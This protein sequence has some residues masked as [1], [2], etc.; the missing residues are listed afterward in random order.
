MRA[1]L[2]PARW[3]LIEIQSSADLDDPA[4]VETD[5][6]VV[7]VGVELD[8]QLDVKLQQA[9]L[10]LFQLL[11]HL[12]QRGLVVVPR[13]QGDLFH[14]AS[15]QHRLAEPNKVLDLVLQPDVRIFDDHG[16]RALQVRPHDGFVAV[17]GV[18]V[19]DGEV[20]LFGAF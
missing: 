12:S 5:F 8:L 2:K 11:C 7:D 13:D 10:E 17:A 14:G 6:A 18:S 4:V 3:L 15:F 16:L 9:L 19:E 20:L 1:N